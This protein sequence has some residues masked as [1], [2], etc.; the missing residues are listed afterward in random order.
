MKNCSKTVPKDRSGLKKIVLTM[1]LI[2]IL[3]FVGFVYTNASGY[4]QNFKFTLN[5]T[6]TS[7]R[8]VLKELE[9]KSGFRF[10]YSDDLL[11]LNEKI[12]IVKSNSSVEEILENILE[13]SNLTFRVLEGN[14]II[15]IPANN[16]QEIVVKGKVVDISGNPLPGVNVVEKGTTIGAVTDLDGNYNIKVSSA[17]ATFML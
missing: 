5:V 1:K 9:E 15:I 16:F 4:S 7:V 14:L 3:T 11:K 8:E 12:S 6:Q 17:D 10:F 13:D 2:T